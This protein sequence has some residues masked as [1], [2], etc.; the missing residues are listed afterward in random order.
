[1]QEGSQGWGSVPLST[2]TV[3]GGLDP[4][5]PSSPGRE[6]RLFPADAS[7]VID[8]T[9][10]TLD[11]IPVVAARPP[12]PRRPSMPP[13][14]PARPETLWAAPL[15]CPEDKALKLLRPPRR[16]ARREELVWVRQGWLPVVTLRYDYTFVPGKRAPER[17]AHVV[18]NFE[19]LGG[20]VIHIPGA[21]T[22][23]Q[24]APEAT[25]SVR[26]ELSAWAVRD[27]VLGAWARLLR[28]EGDADIVAQRSVL[29]SYLVPADARTLDVRVDST[30]L[31]P[32]Y[33]ALLAR[34]PSRRLVVVE[35]LRG[36]VHAHLSTLF[37]RRGHQVASQLERAR[38]IG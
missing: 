22:P 19:P 5:D 7:G 18:A 27:Q 16:L 8:T 35:G 29:A 4:L 25:A 11:R 13:W 31:L 24:Q 3:A 6:L 14:T 20:D 9:A 33:A 36:T 2:D 10:H 30:F 23:L 12:V 17:F 26:P 28:A 37:T 34:G 15:L 1:V 32:F 21:G 38:S